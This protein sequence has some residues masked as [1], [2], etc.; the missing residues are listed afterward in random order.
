MTASKSKWFVG[1]SNKRISGATNNA[2]ARDTL[3]LQPPDNDPTG[4]CNIACE[5]PR[6]PKIAAALA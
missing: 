5:N 3:I 6:P 4:L 2:L 1:S